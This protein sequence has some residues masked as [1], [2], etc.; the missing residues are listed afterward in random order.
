MDN[1]RASVCVNYIIIIAG[2]ELNTVVTDAKIRSWPTPFG[3]R[4]DNDTCRYP[5]RN[6]KNVVS[7][8][9]IVFFIPCRSSSNVL[10]NNGFFS[11]KPKNMFAKS[12]RNIFSGR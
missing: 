7:R 1:A 6:T 11:Q 3:Q 4:L 8:F 5:S 10:I 2:K 12:A 9:S